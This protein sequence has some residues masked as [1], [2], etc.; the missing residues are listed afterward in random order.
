MAQCA[1]VMMHRTERIDRASVNCIDRK[2][3]CRAQFIISDFCLVLLALNSQ[4]FFTFYFFSNLLIFFQ[5]W[6]NAKGA[7]TNAYSIALLGSARDEMVRTKWIQ[8]LIRITALYAQQQQLNMSMS[9]A[10]LMSS[11]SNASSKKG[12]GNAGK[13]GGKAGKASSRASAGPALTPLLMFASNGNGCDSTPATTN[14]TH[15][16]RPQ[17]WASS[18]GS[19]FFSFLF[20]SLISVQYDWNF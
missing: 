17:S 2:M 18:E 7:D 16:H 10:E 14:N 6:D 5:L 12:G 8:R 19:F 3:N 11:S 13:G 20:S 9:A 15:L 4:I 1:A